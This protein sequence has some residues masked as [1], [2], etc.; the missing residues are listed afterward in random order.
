MWREKIPLTA[1][2]LRFWSQG[3]TMQSWGMMIPS[4]L[5]SGKVGQLVCLDWVVLGLGEHG[6]K[7]RIGISS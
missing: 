1:P 6:N 3:V 5:I 7:N 4:I 2:V